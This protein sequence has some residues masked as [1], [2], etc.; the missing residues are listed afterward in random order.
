[1]EQDVDQMEGA[2][3]K[4]SWLWNSYWLGAQ[5][6]LH[7]ARFGNLITACLTGIVFGLLCLVSPWLAIGLCLV[8][9]IFLISLSNPIILCYLVI[10]AIILM[11]GIER[12][13]LI[14]VLSGNEVSLLGALA[15]ALI[16]VLS[17]RRRKV[18]V[19]PYFGVAFLVLIGGTVIVPI[20]TY[21]LQGT[22]LTLG[23]SFKM[24][25]L[26]QYFILF[27][28]FTALPQSKDDRR[29][30]IWWMLAFGSLVAVI[31][32]L[33]GLGIGMVKR[34]LVSLYSSS[35]EL[36]ASRAGRITSLL[37]SWNS[38]GIFMM[39][40][41]I[42]CWAVLFDIKRASGRLL[43]MGMMALSALCLIASGSF[44]GIVGTVIGLF[45]IQLLNHR[46]ARTAPI[47][48]LGFLGV[49]L[50]I[51]IFYPFLQP[52]IEKRLSYQYRYG[53]MIPETLLFRFKIWSEIFIP[54]IRQHFPLPV[55]PT[56][57]ST[58]AWQFEESQYILLLFR[59]GLAGFASYLIWIVIT[60]GWLY[61]SCQ[62]STGFDRS[63]AS[64]ALTIIV[65]LIIAGFTNE[66]F[67]FSGTIDYLW[68]MLALVANNSEKI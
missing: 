43:I 40:I 45:I 4:T 33:Q 8:I 63:I 36:M 37:G 27:W 50:S 10:S 3:G 66:V 21:L 23:N 14:P 5:N 2:S 65:M 34:L 15:V 19:T 52:L 7:G 18:V 38:L 9:V 22:Q 68:M 32:L 41:I 62:R 48:I 60:I 51:F 39:S 57:P 30:I 49:I 61:R 47:L 44:A 59:T 31:G 12:G 29:K 17:D 11:S 6:I 16:I 25:G 20:A 1:M 46:G 26:I 58:F 54:A 53:G 28:L 64:A 13:R 55:Y 56:V 35:H 67:S 24:A 42:I